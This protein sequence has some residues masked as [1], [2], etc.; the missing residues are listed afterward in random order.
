MN[1][2]WLVSLG[3]CPYLEGAFCV[4]ERCFEKRITVDWELGKMN[5]YGTIVIRT[6]VK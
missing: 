2:S 6:Y 3:W 1:P 5:D 4:P